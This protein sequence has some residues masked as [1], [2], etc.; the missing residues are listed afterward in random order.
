MASCS[1]VGADEVG[2]AVSS[3]KIADPSRLTCGGRGGIA[4]T[5]VAAAYAVLMDAYRLSSALAAY[6]QRAWASTD[7]ALPPKGQSEVWTWII[8][9]AK[10]RLAIP[11]KISTKT[12]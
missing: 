2:S 6:E 5:T 7:P 8:E 9:F 11:W 4:G 1:L 10:P 3:G 12:S